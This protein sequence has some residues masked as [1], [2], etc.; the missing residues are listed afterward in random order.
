MAANLQHSHK[1]SRLGT[2]S[3]RGPGGEGGEAFAD[4]VVVGGGGVI[5]VKF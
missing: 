1:E 3:C 2:N 4:V 5:H